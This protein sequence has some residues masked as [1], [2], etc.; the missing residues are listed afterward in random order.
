[1]PDENTCRQLRQIALDSRQ[2]AYSPY[3]G[4]RVGAALL[5][6]GGRIFSG[7]N[8]ENAS[9][10]LSVCAERNAF[11]KAVSEGCRDF[12]AL[13][14]AGSG[15]AMISPCGACLQV[16]AEFAPDLKIILVHDNG[17]YLCYSLKDFLPVAFR[18]EE[19]PEI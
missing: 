3:S 15:N 11:F 1:M 12:T 17:G 5:E 4:F 9:Y 8:V 7:C 14:I 19:S 10:G 2:N 16:M 13:A 6:N 18:L